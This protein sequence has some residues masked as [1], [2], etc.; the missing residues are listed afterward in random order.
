MLPPFGSAPTACTFDSAPLHRLR[1]N[2]YISVVQTRRTFALFRG[3]RIRSL[4]RHGAEANSSESIPN[5]LWGGSNSDLC[6]KLCTP[7]KN[8]SV[9]RPWWEG[10]RRFGAISGGV[11]LLTLQAT[12]VGYE[13]KAQKSALLDCPRLAIEGKS[14]ARRSGYG[15][16]A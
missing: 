16:K 4:R 13:E 2:G 6:G 15:P 12:G 8:C 3:F 11:G 14:A 9:L 5:D 1:S 10:L 7:W